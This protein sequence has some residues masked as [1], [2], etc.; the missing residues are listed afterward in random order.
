MGCEAHRQVAL[1]TAYQSIVLLKNKGSLLPLDVDQVKR[2]AVLG[3]NA[4]D[5][6]AQLGDWVSWSGQLGEHALARQRES[7]VTVL[8]GIRN[9]VADDCEVTYFKGCEAID[10]EAADIAQAVGM[11][12]QA[13]V[14][15]VVV[16][17]V[18]S[19]AGECHDRADLDL[20]GRNGSWFRLSLP[21]AR[22]R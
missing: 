18:L 15:V 11:A 1:E 13:D 19:Q 22:L 14:A 21:L 8:D 9:R 20:S 4:D 5:V 10:P 16:G 3:P 17:D 2:I 12:K 7:V 6:Q